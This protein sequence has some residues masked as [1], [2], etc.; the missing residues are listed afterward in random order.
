VP[1]YFYTQT[2]VYTLAIQADTQE[3]ADAVADDTDV[4]GEGVVGSYLA[5]K[6]TA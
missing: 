1:T 3:E 4:T 2:V 6:K 5:G